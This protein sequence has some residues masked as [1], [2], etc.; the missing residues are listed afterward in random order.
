MVASAGDP[1]IR[2]RFANPPTGRTAS[3]GRLVCSMTSTIERWVSPGRRPREIDAFR[4][5]SR[6]TTRTDLPL[7][8]RT[9]PTFTAVVVLPPPP[10][11]LKTARIMEDAHPNK[12]INRGLFHDYIG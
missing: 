5:A 3:D 2:K 12:P 4:S 6:S 7:S 9:A 10:C 1:L 11:G 8:A